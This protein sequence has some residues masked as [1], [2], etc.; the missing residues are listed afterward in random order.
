MFGPAG[1]FQGGLGVE[2]L[3]GGGVGDDDQGLLGV[4]EYLPGHRQQRAHAGL[5]RRG[6]KG[7]NP[8]RGDDLGVLFRHPRPGVGNR[9]VVPDQVP[10]FHGAVMVAKD[11]AMVVKDGWG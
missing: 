8:D 10:H 11:T 9:L 5:A 7:D 6:V 4:S 2:V 3:K 1:G